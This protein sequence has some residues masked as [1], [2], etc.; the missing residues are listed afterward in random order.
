MK[1]GLLAS[2]RGGFFF[3][4]VFFYE[5]INGA[6]ANGNWISPIYMGW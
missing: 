2:N 6:T 1:V 3:S 5:L 4:F